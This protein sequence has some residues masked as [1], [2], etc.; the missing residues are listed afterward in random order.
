[1]PSLSIREARGEAL[2]A[3]QSELWIANLDVVLFD[4]FTSGVVHGDD[5]ELIGDLRLDE[6]LLG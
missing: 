4:Q 6:G 1:M 5:C 2:I 3:A